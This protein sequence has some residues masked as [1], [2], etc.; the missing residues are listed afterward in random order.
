[1]KSTDTQIQQVTGPI[2]ASLND[3]VEKPM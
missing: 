1:M 3:R 2:N